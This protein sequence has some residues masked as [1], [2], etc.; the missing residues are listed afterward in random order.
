MSKNFLTECEQAEANKLCIPFAQAVL[1]KLAH[2]DMRSVAY[3]ISEGSSPAGAADNI[4][5]ECPL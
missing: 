4:A 1:L 2:E 5:D 3:P